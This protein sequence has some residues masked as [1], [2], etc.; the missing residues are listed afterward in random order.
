LLEHVVKK[1]QSRCA[2]FITRASALVIGA[3]GADYPQLAAA[4]RLLEHSSAF[5]MSFI[6]QLR[7]SA[8]EL[9]RRI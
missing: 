8:S 7:M 9:P 6:E 4:T 2:I 3:D 1:V 5:H